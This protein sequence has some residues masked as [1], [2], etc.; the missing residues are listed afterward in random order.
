[1]TN[2]ECVQSLHKLCCS[3]MHP[4]LQL[5]LACSLASV[6]L[7]VSTTCELRIAFD[8]SHIMFASMQAI[9]KHESLCQHFGRGVICK[10]QLQMSHASFTVQDVCMQLAYALLPSIEGLSA[11][12]SLTWCLW[13]HI[14]PYCSAPG[15]RTVKRRCFPA[16]NIQILPHFGAALALVLV[17]VLHQY[18]CIVYHRLTSFSTDFHPESWIPEF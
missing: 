3:Q 13:N 11:S 12:V 18:V 2:H 17:H 9:I 15:C 10:L 6:V 7:R 8:A 14:V 1:M 16:S 4:A 5:M